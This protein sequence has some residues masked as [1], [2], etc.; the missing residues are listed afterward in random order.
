MYKAIEISVH[1][2][3]H[4]LFKKKLPVKALVLAGE[5]AGGNSLLVKMI[6]ELCKRYSVPLIEEGGE[7]PSV[8]IGRMALRMLFEGYPLRTVNSHAQPLGQ[9]TQLE[10][11]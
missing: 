6:G 2:T 7:E 4:L 1:R 5:L 8:M 3:I 9:R 10:S 11:M